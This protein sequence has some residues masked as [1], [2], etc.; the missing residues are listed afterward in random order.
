LTFRPLGWGDASACVHGERAAI[1][2]QRV[3]FQNS[4]IA[5]VKSDNARRIELMPVFHH[6]VNR[7][8]SDN[9]T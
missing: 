2:R 6:E 8:L 7:D 9:E 5:P 1:D 3:V 4:R